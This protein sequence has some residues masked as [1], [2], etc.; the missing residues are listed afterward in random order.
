MV[1]GPERADHVLGRLV[2]LSSMML[3][4]SDQDDEAGS[5]DRHD[6]TDPCGGAHVSQGRT[7]E[8]INTHPIRESASGCGYEAAVGGESQDR[9]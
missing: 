6:S 5:A 9:R 2:A 1:M 7:V 8:A 3:V 4:L